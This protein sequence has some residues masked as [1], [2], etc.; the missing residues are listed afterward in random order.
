MKIALASGKG[1][2]GKTTIA[3]NF[4]YFLSKNNEVTLLDCDVEE[5]NAHI[6]IKPEWNDNYKTYLTIPEVDLDKCIHCG[7]CGDLCQF[8][9]ITNI[10]DKVLTFPE[11]CHGC[12]LC[13]LACPTGA[14]SEGQR[15]IGT[16]E[17]GQKD[18]IKIVHG[19][20]RIGEAMSPPLIKEVKNKAPKE[21][22]TIIDAP[23]GTSCPVIAAIEDTDFV[24]LVT[25]PT[26]FGLNDLRLAVGM[27][28]TMDIPMAVAINRADI[29]DQE[30]Q[31]YCKEENI[32]IFLELPNKREAAQNYS[33]GKLIL[34][35]MPEFE[36]HFKKA[37]AS[38]EKEL[39]K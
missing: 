2:T 31:K 12:G 17:I 26:P 33:K 38:I 37:I 28:R 6:F 18:N 27:V 13:M 1:G 14:I 23:P 34:Q 30:V 8:S 20:L 36:E 3:T 9:A 19:K 5:P 21:G 7:L 4:A 25:E 16:V 39:R 22:I 35:E 15:E 10:K 24:L 29:G 32:P 11:L